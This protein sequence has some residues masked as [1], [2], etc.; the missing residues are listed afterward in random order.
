[1]RKRSRATKLARSFCSTAC[2]REWLKANV[3]SGADHPQYVARTSAPC[4]ACG[5]PI[6]GM[7]SQFR[8]NRGRFCSVEC[9]VKWQRESGYSSGPKSGSWLG[10]YEEYYGSSWPAQRRKARHRDGYCCQR[11]GISEADLGRQLDVHHVKPLREFDG[12]YGAANAL[13]NLMSLCN[14]CHLMVEHATVGRFS[15]KRPSRALAAQAS[16]PDESEVS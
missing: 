16:D 9:R 2:L 14:P 4:E 3:P 1:M 12:D 10:G 8:R 5:K 7:P 6:E 15:V 13:K 11:C